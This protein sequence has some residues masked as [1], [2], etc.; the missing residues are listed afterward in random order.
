MKLGQG[1]PLTEIGHPPPLHFLSPPSLTFPGVFRVKLHAAVSMRRGD[2]VEDKTSYREHIQ[3][4]VL[5]PVFTAADIHEHVMA[6]TVQVL[7]GV[8]E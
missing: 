6:M 5:I 4:G 1:Q 2:E 7:V 3:R 8:E